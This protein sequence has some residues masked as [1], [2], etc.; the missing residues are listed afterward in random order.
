MTAG[1]ASAARSAKGRRA[2]NTL[3]KG[4]LTFAIVEMLDNRDSGFIKKKWLKYGFTDV[5]PIWGRQTNVPT[6]KSQKSIIDQWPTFQ[7]QLSSLT[8]DWYYLS[9]HHGRQ[10]GIDGSTSDTSTHVKD[11]KEIGFFNHWYHEGTWDH[12]AP[13]DPLKGQL[14][15]EVYMTSTRATP[16]L[17]AGPQDNPLH[18]RVRSECRGVICVSCNNLVYLTCRQALATFFP[19]AVVI[20]MVY[21]NSSDAMPLMRRLLKVCKKDFFIK[22][23]DAPPDELCKKLNPHP[24]RNL[25][26]ILGVQ[27]DGNLTFIDVGGALKTIPIADPVV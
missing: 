26:D 10:F 4:G 1:R 11:Q 2:V 9:G 15:L 27:R 21:K 8:A 5:S 7:S 20:G 3:N 14:P 18:A 17:P 13:G 24:S 22:P 6:F 12:A 19:N 16:I 25:K 23:K